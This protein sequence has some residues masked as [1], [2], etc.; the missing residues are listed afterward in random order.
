MFRARVSEALIRPMA[1]EELA[2]ELRMASSNLRKRLVLL[3]RSG[4]VKS[5]TQRL[6]I[7]RP[8]VVYFLAQDI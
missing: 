8:K 3:S 4:L 5:T 7:G 2:R 6:A 1:T